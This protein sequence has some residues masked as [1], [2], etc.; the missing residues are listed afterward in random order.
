MKSTL[1][2]VP[3]ATHS[4]IPDFWKLRPLENIMA[5]KILYKAAQSAGLQCHKALKV[6]SGIN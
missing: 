3:M 2:P 5:W 1:V 4:S 6:I